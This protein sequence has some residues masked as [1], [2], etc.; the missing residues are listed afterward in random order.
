VPALPWKCKLC[1][2]HD[3]SGA[4]RCV[5]WQVQ[6]AEVEWHHA[7]AYAKKHVRKRLCAGL[8]VWRGRGCSDSMA[9]WRLRPVGRWNAKVREVR[10]SQEVGVHALAHPTSRNR[11][12]VLPVSRMR[13]CPVKPALG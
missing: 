7:G 9:L 5:I 12:S 4:E 13:E 2:W 6:R 3:G 1:S 10:R 8:L 11:R